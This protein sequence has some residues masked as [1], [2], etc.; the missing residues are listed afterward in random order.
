MR[1]D[2]KNNQLREAHPKPQ[3]PVAPDPMVKCHKALLGCL[4][5]IFI[6]QGAAP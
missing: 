4:V 6:T 2:Y 3:G 5:I 1:H